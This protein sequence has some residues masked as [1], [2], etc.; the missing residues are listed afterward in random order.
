[1]VSLERIQS[2]GA[3]RSQMT[4]SYANSLL[5]CCGLLSGSSGIDS[6]ASRT[7]P[8]PIGAMVTTTLPPRSCIG[9]AVCALL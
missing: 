6:A 5:Q 4:I 8:F 9:T 3:G 1:M 7:R 2:Q